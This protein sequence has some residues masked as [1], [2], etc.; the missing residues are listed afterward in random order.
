MNGEIFMQKKALLALMLAATLL[1]SSCAVI[2][3]DEAV[4]R[5]TVII[6]K[7]DTVVTKGEVQDAVDYQLNYT[8]Y[9]YYLYGSS[10]DTTDPSNIASAQTSAIESFEQ[11]IVL[12]EHIAS[13]L[14]ELTEEQLAEIQETAQS[15][16]DSDLDYAKSSEFADSELEGDELTEAVKAWMDENEMT[17]DSYVESATLSKQK[18]LL[19]AEIIKDVEVTE[20]ELT[21]EFN[22][23]VETAQTTYGEDPGSYAT[24]VNNGNTIYYAPAG[25]RR[26]KQILTKFH[27]DDQAVIDEA[28]TK[29]SDAN[30]AVSAANAKITAAQ[31][32]LDSEEAAEEDKTQAQPDLDAANTELEAASADLAAAQAELE[33]ARETAFA[34]LDEE[35]DAILAELDA[36]ADWET[37]MAEKNQDPG[38]QS[39]ASAEKGYAVSAEMTSFDSA[40]VE[41]AMAL[42]NVGDY[43]GK[44]RGDAYGYYIIKYIGDEPEG[45][46]DMET[47]RETLTSSLLTTKQ[48]NFYNETVD[49]WVADAGF[50]V[51]LKALNN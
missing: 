10:Y 30:S 24:A 33:A 27:D 7:G 23:K 13:D 16:Y 21:E 9:M 18:E 45:P 32:I 47:V 12:K 34:N 36:G 1:L 19:K 2:V 6:R 48:N 11:D 42:E 4:D 35:T 8:A 44:I 26:V 3:K 17:L 5:Q 39:G 43:S 22:S 31:E 49:K 37:L 28:N 25:V 15:N 14:G 40:F 51:D 38:M 29:I 50:K 20:E 46:I 41:A